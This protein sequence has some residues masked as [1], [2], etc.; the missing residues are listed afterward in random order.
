MNDPTEPD[1]LQEQRQLLAVSQRLGKLI[2]S[3]DE[4]DQLLDALAKQLIDDDIFDNLGVVLVNAKTQKVEP[5]LR[6]VRKSAGESPDPSSPASF[7]GYRAA[8]QQQAEEVAQ[9]GKTVILEAKSNDDPIPDG[10]GN[11]RQKKVCFY[12]PIK[13]KERVL[14]VLITDCLPG[15]KQSM[16]ERLEPLIDQLAIGLM[17]REL[18]R[19]FEETQDYLIRSDKMASLGELAAGVAHEINNPVGFVTSNLETLTD[20]IDT[21]MKLQSLYQEMEKGAQQNGAPACQDALRQIAELRRHGPYLRNYSESE[22]IRPPG[23]P[24]TG[25]MRF[26]GKHRG[27]PAHCV[28]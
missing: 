28:E 14:A 21:L 9:S 11:Q 27:N 6:F 25:S 3:L 8:D 26:E 10:T 2:L 18:N 5:A 17:H 16:L 22:K 24:G 7:P 13:Q 1:T 15:E 20:Y 4:P 12:T 23:R 19:K